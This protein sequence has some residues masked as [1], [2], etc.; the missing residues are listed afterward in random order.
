MFANLLA[1]GGL[2]GLES[3][4]VASVES[5]ERVYEPLFVCVPKRL[6]DWVHQL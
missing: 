4:H 5:I 3:F 1:P 6:Q 2:Q